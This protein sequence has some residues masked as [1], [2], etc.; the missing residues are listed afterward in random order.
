MIDF[1]HSTFEGFLNDA[2]AYEG[3]DDGVL[4]GLSSLLRL[5]RATLEQCDES[6]P[7]ETSV[8]P[9]VVATAVAAVDA[10]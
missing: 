7:S 1:A 4:L 3:A 8:A 10:S 6:T 9:S 5:A 2:P